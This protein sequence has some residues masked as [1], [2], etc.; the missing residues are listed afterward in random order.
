MMYISIYLFHNHQIIYIFSRNQQEMQEVNSHEED[1]GRNA[2]K[3]K[4]NIEVDDIIMFKCQAYEDVKNK[5]S[6]QE[7]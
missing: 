3:Y 1:D 5:C 4:S 7:K 2:M 6:T